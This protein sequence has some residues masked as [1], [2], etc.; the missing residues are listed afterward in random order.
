M[1][2]PDMEYPSEE[3]IPI[4]SDSAQHVLIKICGQSI[5]CH[6]IWA[7]RKCI[8]KMRQLLGLVM[9]LGWSLECWILWVDY[10][11][12]YG[13]H[14]VFSPGSELGNS[15]CSSF[16]PSIRIQSYYK[17]PNQTQGYICSTMSQQYLTSFCTY[18]STLSKSSIKI[19]LKLKTH[20]QDIK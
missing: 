18:F 4:E 20:K 8:L 1:Y 15:H 12:I 14:D 17:R 10:C 11:S 13:L 7:S 19:S 6:Q 9:N 3:F 16:H 5:L 2:R